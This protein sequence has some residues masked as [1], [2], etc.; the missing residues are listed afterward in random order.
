[1]TN[2]STLADVLNAFQT[3]VIGESNETYERFLFN[4]RV[5]EPGE[6]FE[7]FYADL[8]RLM[9][10]CNYCDSCKDSILRDRIV[11]GINDSVVQK[12]LLKIRN[13]TLILSILY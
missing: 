13:L 8:Q 11:L 2:T 6:R 9:S 1:M 3:F 7:Y 5:Q 12:D 4:R 10:T